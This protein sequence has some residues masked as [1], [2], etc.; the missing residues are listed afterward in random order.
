M[1][2]LEVGRVDTLM[3]SSEAL[4]QRM[5]DADTDLDLVECIMKYVQGGDSPNGIGCAEQ[6]CMVSSLRMLAG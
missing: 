3:Q 2:C 4:E 1:V 6:T 5:E